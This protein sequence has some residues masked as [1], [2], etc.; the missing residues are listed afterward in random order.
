MH[1]I[2]RHLTPNG[3]AGLR[4]GRISTRKGAMSHKIGDWAG[5][6]VSIPFA[7]PRAPA[8]KGDSQIRA[9]HTVRPVRS[10]ASLN[11]PLPCQIAARRRSRRPRGIARRTWLAGASRV[12]QVFGAGHVGGIIPCARCGSIP[13]LSAIRVRFRPRCAPWP[14][15]SDHAGDRDR[16]NYRGCWKEKVTGRGQRDTSAI[17][18]LILAVSITAANRIAVSVL[19]RAMPWGPCCWSKTAWWTD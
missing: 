16:G 7:L 6:R 8:R 3:G 13:A 1:C 15:G 14:P 4:G 9:G 19:G 12:A 17:R 18:A 2:H 10:S 5:E 11:R